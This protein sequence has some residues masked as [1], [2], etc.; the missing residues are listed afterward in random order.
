[1]GNS[2]A[3]SRRR[4][5]YFPQKMLINEQH[6]A[7]VGLL[8]KSASEVRLDFVSHADVPA[9]AAAITR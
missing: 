7:L 4:S 2:T 6:S 3:T 8:W 5:E 9:A 1:M